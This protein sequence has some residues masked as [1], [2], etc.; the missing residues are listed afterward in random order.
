MT[1]K[2]DMTVANKINFI[3]HIDKP[4][5]PLI[6]SVF[7]MRLLITVVKLFHEI[8]FCPYMLILILL[9]VKWSVLMLH[10]NLKMGDLEF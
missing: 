1:R 3:S 7:T 9:K 2:W 8:H 6:I 10:S 5:A 4:N